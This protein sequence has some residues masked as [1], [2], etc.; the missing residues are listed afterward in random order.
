MAK[1]KKIIGRNPLI[2]SE[3]NLKVNTIITRPR[4]IAVCMAYNIGDETLLDFLK[5]KGYKNLNKN[6]LL[7]AKALDFISKE[8]ESDKSIKDKLRGQTAIEFIDV[9]T[10]INPKFKSVNKIEEVAIQTST[11]PALYLI[12]DIFNQIKQKILYKNY[13]IL[14]SNFSDTEAINICSKMSSS[15]TRNL[16]NQVNTS[17]GKRQLIIYQLHYIANRSRDIFGSKILTFIYGLRNLK[18]KNQTANEI[19][20]Y[21]K[22]VPS[23]PIFSFN[24]G[25]S[26]LKISFFIKQIK[27]NNKLRADIRIFDS[28][29]FEEIGVIDEDGYVIGKLE[30]FKPQL[31]LFHNATKNNSFEIFSGVETGNCE[32]C[33]R[34]LSHPISLRIGIGPLCAA[35]K[36]LDRVIYNFKGEKLI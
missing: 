25:H 15:F 18:F 19:Q 22:V 17:R 36:Q 8:F 33:G 7:D 3:D 27:K 13:P 16:C 12:D 31:T 29:E 32:I 4:V 34:E 30:K 1:E 28:K 26:N 2:L 20:I 23:F 35:N 11:E 21:S 9:I 14:L 6:S 5:G 10:T 24:S